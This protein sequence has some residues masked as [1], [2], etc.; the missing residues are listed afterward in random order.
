[1]RRLPSVKVADT[2]AFTLPQKRHEAG[3]DSDTLVSAAPGLVSERLAKVN[4]GAA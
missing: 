4:D 2:D 3:G 1:L